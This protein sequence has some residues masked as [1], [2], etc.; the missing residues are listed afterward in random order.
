MSQFEKRSFS[1][2]LKLR[3]VAWMTSGETSSALSAELGVKR[4]M[5]YR[6][7]DVVRRDG[8][9]AIP[10]KPGRRSKA[11]LL[12]REHGAEGATELARARR[13]IAEL[14]RKVE[15]IGGHGSYSLILGA[16]G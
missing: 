2:E 7:H 12:T 4:T 3:A 1:R 8:E 9:A 5:L 14:E 6:W 11:A 15:V 10:G 16:A 13:K